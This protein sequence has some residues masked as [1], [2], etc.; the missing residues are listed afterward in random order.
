MVTLALSKGRILK[1]EIALLKAAGYDM[2]DIHKDDRKLLFKYPDKG[3]NIILLKPFD[4]P[5]YVEKG[6]ADLGI[7]GKDVIMEERREI[8]SLIDLGIGRCR[9]SVAA[10]KK[11]QPI[12][13]EKL[14]IGTKYPEITEEY[15][16]KKEMNVEIIK[17]YGS[18]EL[19]PLMGIT[20]YIVDIV[21]SGETLRKNGLE[22]VEKICDVT[23]YLIANRAAFKTK[24]IEIKPLLEK[25]RGV[26]I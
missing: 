3:V 5:I 24:Y 13:K 26:Q 1:E 9:I 15:Y 16:R 19:A 25:I 4:V 2:T 21:S 7:V 20:D 22:E 18:I 17:L 23:T 6:A 8:F 12:T 14:R 11:R 10:V